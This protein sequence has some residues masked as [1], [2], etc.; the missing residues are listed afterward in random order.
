MDEIEEEVTEQAL[1]ENTRQMKDP[2]LNEYSCDQVSQEIVTPKPDPAKDGGF[3]SAAFE[4][5]NLQVPN[6]ARKSI[7]TKVNVSTTWNLLPQ[8][9]FEKEID[10]V[11]QRSADR[12]VYTGQ[13]IDLGLGEIAFSELDSGSSTENHE[14]NKSNE[15]D[16][17]SELDFCIPLEKKRS[18]SVV[19]PGVKLDDNTPL[20][21]MKKQVV[22]EV[23]DAT[24]DRVS[25]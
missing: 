17:A 13:L 3:E 11:D 19:T 7:N 14:S 25:A 6:Q 15:I 1:T 21:P 4:A 20:Q 10:Q 22:E 5:Q 23:S 9:H 24:S 18:K 12:D 16:S 8:K 2:S